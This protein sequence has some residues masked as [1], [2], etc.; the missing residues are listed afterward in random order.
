MIGK[1]HSRSSD[2]KLRASFPS[3]ALGKGFAFTFSTSGRSTDTIAC[4]RLLA[5]LRPAIP[6]RALRC[7][8][9]SAAS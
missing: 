5:D 3:C 1:Q 7:A 2:D 8:A 9:C 6:C 4:N